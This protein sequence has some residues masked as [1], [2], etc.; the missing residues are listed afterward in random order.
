MLA[1][2]AT[3]AALDG[4]GVGAVLEVVP[5]G[6]SQGGFK[7]LRP[8]V[9]GLGEPPDLVMRQAEVAEHRREWLAG[10]DG[11]EELLAHLHWQPALRSGSAEFSLCVAVC[12]AAE[13]AAAPGVP[14][15]GC[16]VLRFGHRMDASGPLPPSVA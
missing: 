14:A 10:I 7:R 13:C 8:L 12:L 4:G 2:L 5:A 16:A 9:F 15:C 6:R 11:L 3:Y 1:T